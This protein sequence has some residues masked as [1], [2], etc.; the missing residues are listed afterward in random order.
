MVFVTHHMDDL[1][2]CLSPAY[3]ARAMGKTAGSLFY[4]HP[5]S[6]PRSRYLC[7][8]GM[9]IHE[10]MPRGHI[11]HGGP[12][13]PYYLL[14]HFHSPALVRDAR[15]GA[16]KVEG[17]TILWTPFSD[18]FYG[19]PW[20]P[21]DH[22]W[23]NVY[24][25]AM[26]DMVG[27]E[28]LSVNEPLLV[29]FTPQF[30]QYARLL[31]DELHRRTR[32]DVVMMECIMRMWLHELALAMQ[33]TD[34]GDMPDALVRARQHIESHYQEPV[35]LADLCA[36]SNLS[37]SQLSVLFRRCFG[38]SP[39]EYLIGFRVKRAQLLLA[40]Q[41]LTISEVADRSGFADPLYFSRQFRHR[42]GVSPSEFRVRFV[43]RPPAPRVRPAARKAV[44]ER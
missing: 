19:S 13:W 39:I 1:A 8:E 3:T 14:M 24:G 32:Q 29:S 20:A 2:V 42:T 31:Y 40:Y 16:T 28:R 9:G 30:E 21:W 43:D 34:R 44:T 37:V 33:G 10:L 27:T 22:T 17:R 25:S 38:V 6:Q 5:A 11:R 4:L 15:G 18:H 41:N 7:V 23:L 26:D 36:V 35:S 12:S